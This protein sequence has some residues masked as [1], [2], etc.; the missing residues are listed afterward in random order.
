MVRGWRAAAL[1]K[2]GLWVCGAALAAMSVPSVAAAQD[3]AIE[4]PAPVA[5]TWSVA[6]VGQLI[7]AIEASRAEGLNPADYNP[8]VL[9]R[10]LPEGAGPALDVLADAAAL[11]LAHDYYFGRV[12]D[13]ASVGWLIGR[14]PEGAQ[15]AVR[16]HRA[17]AQGD[18]ASF[19]A[20]LLPSDPR[21][22]ALRE[23]LADAPDA[24]TRDRLRAN[25]ER[26]RWMPRTLGDNYLYV[27]VPSY[28]LRVI[29]NGASL[30]TY[31]VVVGAKDTP[32]PALASPTSSLVVNP[33]WN[34]PVSIV[35]KSN[36]RPGR[37]GFQF[38][39]NRDGSWAVRQ[40][41]GPRN[42]LG[43][44]KFNLVND[45]AIYLHDTPAKALFARQQRAL[46]HGCIR[47]KN[48]D[49]LATQLMDD[50]GEA[51]PLDEALASTQTA[52]LRLPRTWQVY[53]VYFTMDS[54]EPG[55]LVTYDDPY[56]Y[57]ARIVASLDGHPAP[58]A[59]RPTQIASR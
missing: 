7:D 15:L 5:N 6:A 11:T 44:I 40:P 19:Y 55:S 13:H 4:Q 49:R 36:L 39:A 2:R 43:R 10:A 51:L 3:V 27:N 26:W 9:R 29:D 46:S 57:D 32:T 31:T 53:I 35:R 20:S 34:V 30:A 18:L 47:V 23:A 8:A 17:A 38:T 24:A 48:I 37:A 16:L 21:Y 14:P 50:G 56:G 52:T 25:M 22:A 42:S 45:Q 1:A 54:V 41:P 12:S 28:K 59:P 58:P 33:W